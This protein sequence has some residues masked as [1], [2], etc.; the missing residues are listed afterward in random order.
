MALPLLDS[1][2]KFR[3]RFRLVASWLKG[4]IQFE[5]HR[6]IKIRGKVVGMVGLM[7]FTILFEQRF[8]NLFLQQFKG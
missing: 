4:G 2:N 1:I 7:Y 3:D 8:S 6:I 5:I